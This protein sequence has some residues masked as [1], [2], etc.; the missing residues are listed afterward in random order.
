MWT[1]YPV[2]PPLQVTAVFQNGGELPYYWVL[3]GR[4]LYLEGVLE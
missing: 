1:H 2:N 4:R 3:N